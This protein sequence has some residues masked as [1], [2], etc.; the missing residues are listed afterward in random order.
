MIQHSDHIRDRDG[1][2]IRGPLVWFVTGT[3]PTGINQDEVI[4]V[5]Q[6]LDVS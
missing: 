1:P 2:G 6:W 5:P 4:V 3:M